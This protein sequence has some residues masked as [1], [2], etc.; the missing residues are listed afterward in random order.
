MPLLPMT[1][2]YYRRNEFNDLPMEV[3]KV[4]L[5]EPTS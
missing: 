4:T 1:T 3:M 5:D 2:T